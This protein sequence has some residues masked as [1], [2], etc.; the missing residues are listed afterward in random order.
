MIGPLP[1]ARVVSVS[2]WRRP[3]NGWLEPAKFVRHHASASGRKLGLV[4]CALVHVNAL[5]RAGT[6]PPAMAPLPLLAQHWLT[7]NCD[8]TETCCGRLLALGAPRGTLPMPLCL[9]QSNRHTDCEQHYSESPQ[10]GFF[11][12]RLSV[13]TLC[14]PT[15]TGLSQNIDASAKSPETCA[16]RVSAFEGKA[17]ILN[18]GR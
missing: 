10:H 11:L 6:H 13:E 8:T 2:D 3:R 9:S 1:P 5:R 7:T 17:D 14:E 16:N 4:A 15:R 12:P 18:S